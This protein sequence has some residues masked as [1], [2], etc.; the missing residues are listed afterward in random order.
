MK[1]KV[2]FYTKQQVES[3]RNCRLRVDFSDDYNFNVFRKCTPFDR[4]V[5][6]FYNK[7]IKPNWCPLVE[8]EDEENEQ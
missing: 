3:C 4:F 2:E 6:K 5:D 1:Y 7:G 8:C